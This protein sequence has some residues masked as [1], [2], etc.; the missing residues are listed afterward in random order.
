MRFIVATLVSF[1]AIQIAS[2]D[3]DSSCVITLHNQIAKRTDLD[4][5]VPV[6][7]SLG[8]VATLTVVPAP[9]LS[10]LL[11]NIVNYLDDVFEQVQ[12]NLQVIGAAGISFDV[13]SLSDE[14][15]ECL[16]QF[17][18]FLFQTSTPAAPAS[19]VIK[20]IGTAFKNVVSKFNIII[21]GLALTINALSS[22]VGVSLAL[23]LQVTVLGFKTAATT[24][25]ESYIIKSQVLFDLL[26]NVFGS[27]LST[28][29]TLVI[30]VQS[31]Y[32]L[33]VEPMLQIPTTISLLNTEVAIGVQTLVLA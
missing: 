30:T 10:E 25:S 13:A 27:A 33:N 9:S 8:N 29:T 4:L 21:D 26:Q 20:G 19:A 7:A 15:T 3:L 17:K 12:S 23:L 11:T 1:I 32:E 28:C 14:I 24:L 2:A 5:V 22:Q 31:S 6:S 16:H 18:Y